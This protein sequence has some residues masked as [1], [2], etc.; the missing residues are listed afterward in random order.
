MSEGAQIWFDPPESS[1][2]I[3]CGRVKVM[4][5]EIGAASHI[6]AESLTAQVTW[7]ARGTIVEGAEVIVERRVLPLG[8]MPTHDDERV[9]L[10]SVDLEE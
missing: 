10:L 9:M 7:H 5:V 4:R 8:A 2:S 1:Q 6:D 3:R